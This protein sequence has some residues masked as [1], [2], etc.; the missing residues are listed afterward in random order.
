[1]ENI[2]KYMNLLGLEAQDKVTKMKGIISSL[3]FDLYGCIQVTLTP[4]AKNNDKGDS[5]WYDVNRIKVLGKKPVMK[6]PDYEGYTPQSKGEQ[7]C[8]DKPT[9]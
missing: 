2:K 8:C 7:G 3:S 4:L 5:Y 9:I 1:M 6:R